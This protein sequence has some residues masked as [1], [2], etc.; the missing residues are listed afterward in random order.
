MATASPACS[1]TSYTD[2]A[3]FAAAV[4][5]YGFH[6]A[7]GFDS[8]SSGSS[9]ASYGMLNISGSGLASDGE[10]AVTLTL[11][12]TN[13]YPAVS[14]PN[15]VG[16]GDSQEQFLGGNSDTLVFDFACPVHAFGLYLIGNPVPTG[17]TPI[18]F[19]RMT[20][21][22]IGFGLYSSTTPLNNLD[23]GNDVYFMG[24]V[25]PNQTF[26]Q[27]RLESDNDPAAVFSF[28]VDGIALATAA[29]RVSIREAKEL[30]SGN[31][32]I[33][34]VVVMRTHSDRINVEEMDR[35][36]G[37]AVLDS[38]LARGLKASFLGTVERTGD[39]EQVLRMVHVIDTASQTP[40]GSFF[41]GTR[42]LGG[43][44]ESGRQPGCVQSF[45]PNNIG[46]D[47]AICGK[48]SAIGKG[49]AWMTVDDGAGRGSGVFTL[50]VKV[51]GQFG[52]ASRYVGETVRVSGSS[53]LFSLLGEHYPLVRVALP[54]DVTHI[55]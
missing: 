29:D 19:W 28:S 24:V 23:P 1:A 30:E 10:T 45:G 46:L 49:G 41:V 22:D 54:T 53:S 39:D 26:T 2:P 36:S 11:V 4:Q 38:D 21:P 52:A 55:Y 33:S 18:P 35:S 50:G 7:A 16:A 32:V 6:L 17:E 48:V 37:I 25:S 40:P 15:T 3:A 51:V 34:D 12:A 42:A 20:A 31:V 9:A 47:V 5:S 27:V 44:A 13:H 8:Q 14:A 43:G